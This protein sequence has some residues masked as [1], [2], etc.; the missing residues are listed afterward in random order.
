MSSSADNGPR[1]TRAT[2]PAVKLLLEHAQTAYTNSVQLI[3]SLKHETDAS[4]LSP[5]VEIEARIGTLDKFRSDSNKQHGSYKPLISRQQAREILSTLERYDSLDTLDWFTSVD[6]FNNENTRTRLQVHS[7]GL[8]NLCGTTPE[9]SSSWKSLQA[10][11]TDV[12]LCHALAVG[13]RKD[14]VCLDNNE[15]QN[16]AIATVPTKMFLTQM[17]KHKVINETFTLSSNAMLSTTDKIFDVIRLATNIEVPI[18]RR[19]FVNVVDDCDELHM[20]TPTLVRIK[21]QK[22]FFYPSASTTESVR[23][24]GSASNS[25]SGNMNKHRYEFRFDVSQVW[26]GKT[27][28]EAEQQR[29]LGSVAATYEFE[30]EY[31]DP[32]KSTFD[33]IK[34]TS[35]TLSSFAMQT[36]T[37]TSRLLP[38]SHLLPWIQVMHK[39]TDILHPTP[40][41][42]IHA[43]S[44]LQNNAITLAKV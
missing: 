16:P 42:D 6:F 37:T 28:Q 21:L 3:Q 18:Q 33:V 39:L 7:S 40:I 41:D 34:S 8:I 22:S 30:C 25:D 1:A 36:N 27:K 29:A 14:Y 38:S 43:T 35:S 32:N 20:Y 44:L 15:P 9:G 31:L 17:N 26:T 19:T 24:F 13:S 5:T 4:N 2:H 12:D 10:I 11:E 23:S